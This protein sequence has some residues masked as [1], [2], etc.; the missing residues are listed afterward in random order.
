MMEE[1]KLLTFMVQAPAM[2][3][4]FVTERD[5]ILPARTTASA[6]ASTDWFCPICCSK[7]SVTIADYRTISPVV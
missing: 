7:A 5:V 2:S 4:G 1:S 3:D 6:R